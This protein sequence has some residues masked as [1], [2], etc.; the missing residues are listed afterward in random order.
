MLTVSL[1]APIRT[2]TITVTSNL[3]PTRRLAELRSLPRDSPNARQFRHRTSSPK[4]RCRRETHDSPIYRR[5]PTK[6]KYSRHLPTA[7]LRISTTIY[8]RPIIQHQHRQP[9]SGR[10]KCQQHQQRNRRHRRLV[11][12]RLAITIGHP[13]KVYRCQTSLSANNPLP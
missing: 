4:L 2:T 11:S 9:S 13:R 12:A 5:S 7:N 8:Q 3:S 10:Q 1:H 6:P